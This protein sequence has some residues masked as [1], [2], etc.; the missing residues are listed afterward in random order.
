MINESKAFV[1]N[2][3]DQYSPYWIFVTNLRILRDFLFVV[4]AAQGDGASLTQ[5]K[6]GEYASMK[7]GEVKLKSHLNLLKERELSLSAVVLK[8]G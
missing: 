3:K 2:N 1:P 8:Q 7:L 6:A 5:E 4:E